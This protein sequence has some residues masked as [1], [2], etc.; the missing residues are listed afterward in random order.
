MT[1]GAVTATGAGD[2]NPPGLLP[3]LMLLPADAVLHTVAVGI[4]SAVGTASLPLGTVIVKVETLSEH[5]CVTYALVTPSTVKTFLSADVT[6]IADPVAI[7]IEKSDE[8]TSM[9]CR[10]ADEPLTVRL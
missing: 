4:I 7:V 2:P 5:D 10:S 3:L 8:P 6:V 9:D 1:T